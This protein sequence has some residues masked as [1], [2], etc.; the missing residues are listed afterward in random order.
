MASHLRKTAFLSHLYKKTI[1]LPRQARDKHRIL[2]KSRKRCR[3]SHSPRE[4]QQQRVVCLHIHSLI[5]SHCAG[6]RGAVEHAPK[7]L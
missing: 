4:L 2:G 5:R 1:V 3:F 7:A 6:V